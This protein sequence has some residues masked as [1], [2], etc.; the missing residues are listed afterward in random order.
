VTLH[1]QR[2]STPFCDENFS[3]TASVAENMK[4]ACGDYRSPAS[5][6]VAATFV[7][8]N[9]SAGIATRRALSSVNHQSL[10]VRGEGKGVQ[11]RR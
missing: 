1:L 9:T 10:G 8:A 6:N 11:Q 7:S 2:K 4:A 3:L 5:H